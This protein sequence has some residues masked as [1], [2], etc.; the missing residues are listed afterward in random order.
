MRVMI[1]EHAGEQLFIRAVDLVPFLSEKIIKELESLSFGKK[2]VKKVKGTTV[3]F[4]KS[5]SSDTVFMKTAWSN[6][7]ANNTG[8]IPTK[9]AV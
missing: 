2:L 7:P 4:K 8:F 1:D 6:R 9:P 5:N 3:V